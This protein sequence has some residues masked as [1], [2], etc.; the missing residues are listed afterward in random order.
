[1]ALKFLG[2]L[3]KKNKKA[4]DAPAKTEKSRI[5]TGETLKWL[6]AQLGRQI[7]AERQKFSALSLELQR[8]IRELHKAVDSLRY[9]KFEEGDRTYAAINMIKDT[10]MKKAVMSL[11]SYGREVDAGRLSQ[12][13]IDFP[14]F[15]DM[16]QNTVKLTG[17]IIMVPKQRLVMS[18]YFEKENR[19]IS[20][21][22]QLIASKMEEIRL[23]IN[24]P[25]VL[26]NIDKINQLIG[27]LSS[28]EK[29]HEVLD[30]R[31][32]EITGGIASKENEHEESRGKFSGIEKSSEWKELH[33]I[34]SRI[35]DGI[36]QKEELENEISGKLGSMKRVFK[37]FA[38]DAKNLGKDDRR[39]L[40]GL[41]HS[42][43]KTFVSS[44]AK[45]IDK[46]FH[47]LRK[48]TGDGSFRLSEK[49]RGKMA[50]L[51]GMLDS[52]W[53]EKTKSTYEKTLR[54]IEESKAKKDSISVTVQKM[55]A[56]RKLEK[57]G[58]ELEMMKRQKSEA[59]RR[60][61]EKSREL[62][63][64]KKEISEFIKKELGSEVE[65]R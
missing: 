41:S 9:K 50:P 18:R 65:I 33:W 15:R 32:K 35:N 30:Q 1:M 39:M 45:S 2:G 38:H 26:K 43:L 27:E 49:D 47:M 37:L 8:M 59:E 19:K 13:S 40:E 53:L 57:T 20:N 10:W 34:D 56:S 29:E 55:E 48:E 63:D 5:E 31:L 28:V 44:D 58:A 52:G 16:Y 11:N 24:S 22:L 21:A 46:I 17:E 23:L 42:P 3:F 14:A 6:N 4:E 61:S 36:G 60:L 51:I 62:K 7:E 64:K 25:G 54:D 12:G